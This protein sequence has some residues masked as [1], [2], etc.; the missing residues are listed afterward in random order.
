MVNPTDCRRWRLILSAVRLPWSPR[1]QSTAAG[2]AAKAA[3]TTIPVVF[4]TGLDPVEAG[5]VKSLSRP[6]GNVTGV[7]SLNATVGPKGLELLHELIPQAK[8]FSVLVNRANAVAADIIM[9]G[10]E[11]SSRAFGL[12]LQVLD[13]NT[14]SDFDAVFAKRVKPRTGGLLHH[15]RALYSILRHNS[16]PLSHSKYVCCQRSMACA[17]LRSLAD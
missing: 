17:S 11:A 5:L 15:P 2:L 9:K 3:T 1:P 4:E 16:L 7:T 13:A 14:G 10:V 12:E 8:N 6:E